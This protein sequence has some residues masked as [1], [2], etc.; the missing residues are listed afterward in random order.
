MIFLGID[1]ETIHG[2]YVFTIIF[3][4]FLAVVSISQLIRVEESSGLI[5]LYRQADFDALPYLRARF[6]FMMSVFLSQVVVYLPFLIQSAW[7]STVYRAFIDQYATIAGTGL[8]L[9]FGYGTIFYIGGYRGAKW[10]LWIAMIVLFFISFVIGQTISIE[11]FSSLPFYLVLLLVLISYLLSIFVAKRT[12]ASWKVKHLSILYT[13]GAAFLFIIGCF[14]SYY[15]QDRVENALIDYL[16][17]HAELSM[18]FY[19]DDSIGLYEAGWELM[20]NDDGIS[21]KERY[22]LF[23]QRLFPIVYHE[24]AENWMPKSLEFTAFSSNVQR[25]EQLTTVSTY[26]TLSANDYEAFINSYSEGEVCLVITDP[27]M[28]HFQAVTETK[29]FACQSIEIK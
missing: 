25:P 21:E 27:S 8:L 12:F 11:Q 15:E 14:F 29:E 3:S 26:T 1:S 24:Q 7:T 13:A 18:F 17:Q 6:I 10:S 16:D 4:L 5:Q 2:H 20:M 19:K 9:L 23:N 22:Y 28:Q